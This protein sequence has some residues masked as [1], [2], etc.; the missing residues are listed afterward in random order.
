MSLI[1]QKQEAELIQGCRRGDDRHLT[2]LVKTYQRQVY[3]LA[4]KF[5]FNPAEAEDLT[6][7]IF[8]KVID[9]LDRFQDKSRLGT[10]ITSIA[11]NHCR[12]NWRKARRQQDART[13]AAEEMMTLPAKGRQPEQE[14]LEAEMIEHLHTSITELPEDLREV[15]MLREFVEMSHE[16]IAD[17]LDVPEGTVWSRLNRAR[18]LLKDKMTEYM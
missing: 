10:W 9:H 18:L 1:E 13:E 16:E 7:E 2:L 5:T 14:A 15:V 8:M 17:L 11:L 12:T 6:Q 3:A 4:L